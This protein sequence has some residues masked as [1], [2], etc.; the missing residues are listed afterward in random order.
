MKNPALLTIFDKL[1][2][3]LKRCPNCGGRFVRI[4]YGMP[5]PSTEAAARAGTILLGGCI[6]D[7][8]SPIAKCSK[9][10]TY[11]NSDFSTETFTEEELKIHRRVLNK[12]E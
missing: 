7:H 2:L 4:V 6:F 11:L 8:R 9:C 1:R 10:H 3:R 12:Q 5:T